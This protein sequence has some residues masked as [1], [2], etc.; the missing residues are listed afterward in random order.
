MEPRSLPGV[1]IRRFTDAD[2]QGMREAERTHAELLRVYDELVW[3]Y[4]P[5]RMMT[6]EDRSEA[7]AHY[8]RFS[9]MSSLRIDA[10]RRS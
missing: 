7:I 4:A 2:R 8:K 10:Y 1:T 9:R 6:P 3:K 5:P